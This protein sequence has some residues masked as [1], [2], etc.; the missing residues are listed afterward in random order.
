MS[1]LEILQ[2]K[3]DKQIPKSV[4][5]SLQSENTIKPELSDEENYIL[6]VEDSHIIYWSDHIFEFW[7]SFVDNTYDQD[8][9]L[10]MKHHCKFKNFYTDVITFVDQNIKA[11]VTFN[12]IDSESD[13]ENYDDFNL[14]DEM[15]INKLYY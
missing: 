9:P 14:I 10:L 1:Y 4:C 13:E 12:E 2:K 5:S 8:M 15:Y 7:R 3:I 6:N 11:E